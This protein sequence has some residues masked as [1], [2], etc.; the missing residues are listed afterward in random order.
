MLVSRLKFGEG[1]QEKLDLKVVG[2]FSRSIPLVDVT[3]DGNFFV[4]T[5]AIPNSGNFVR[6]K[7]WGGCVTGHRELSRH[8][9]AED[10]LITKA[11]IGIPSRKRSDSRKNADTMPIRRGSSHGFK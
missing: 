9:C 7:I 4:R 11:K 1:K 5:Q 8:F 2:Q 6:F 3:A 10:D